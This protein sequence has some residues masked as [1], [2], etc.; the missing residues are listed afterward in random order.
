MNL[1]STLPNLDRLT[2][3]WTI[4]DVRSRGFEMLRL[5]LCCAFH[6]FGEAPEYVVCVNS[7]SLEEAQA[8]TG[9]LPAALSRKLR[10]RLSTRAD[11][12]D[13]LRAAFS[14]D[15]IEGMGWKLIPLRLALDR[16]E[17]A[18]DNDCILYGVPEGLRAWLS[19]ESSALFAED[20]D[21]AL[22]LFDP[23]CPPG[24]FNAGIRGLAPGVDLAPALAAALADAAQL[25]GLS[26][27]AAP[28]LQGEIEEQGLQ[29]AAMFRLKVPAPTSAA[30]SSSTTVPLF[31]VRNTEVTLCSPFWPR[32]PELGPCGAHFIG[33]NAA[34]IPWNYY[35]RP[36]DDWLHEHWMRHRPTLYARAGLALPSS[37]LDDV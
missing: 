10:W 4:G 29:A 30:V 22:G 27:G 3:R 24:N 31:W 12:P 6:L 28:V 2:L 9:E 11:I 1:Y 18:L 19:T 7:V 16:W 15:V 35:D 36:A 23:L 34:H 20:V 33:M 13:V 32:N 5:A 37:H 21:R 25:Q 17:L 26:L 14:A 8:R